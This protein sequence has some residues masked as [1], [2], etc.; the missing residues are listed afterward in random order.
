MSKGLFIIPAYNEE[1][2][3]ES[4]LDDAL[5]LRE[6]YPRWDLLVIDDG[7]S[8]CTAEIARAKGVNVIRFK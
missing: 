7:S 1:K 3:I 2:H 5:S 4:V 6:L 8:D